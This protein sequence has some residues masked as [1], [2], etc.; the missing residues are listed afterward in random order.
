MSNLD[1]VRKYRARNPDAVRAAQVRY[2][3][4]HPERL[5]AYRDRTKEQRSAAYYANRE[6][7]LEQVKIRSRRLRGQLE[8]P[9]RPMPEKCENPG[10]PGIPQKRRLAEDHDHKTG[11]F[12][13]W[14]CGSCNTAIGKLGDSL[15]GILATAQYFR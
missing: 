1:A 8:A 13:G 14:L 11:K 9:T 4:A 10:C 7:R 15:E 3:A 12:R 2:R 5:Q 6:A